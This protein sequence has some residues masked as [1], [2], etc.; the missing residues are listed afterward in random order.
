MQLFSDIPSRNGFD[1]QYISETVWHL[2]VIHDDSNLSKQKD[3]RRGKSTLPSQTPMVLVTDIYLLIFWQRSGAMHLHLLV[4][5]A[6][7]YSL[8]PWS[9]LELFMI[10]MGL[11]LPASTRP[12]QKCSDWSKFNYI[13]PMLLI[14][15]NSKQGCVTPKT[16]S[17]RGFSCSGFWGSGTTFTSPNSTD[18]ENIPAFGLDNDALHPR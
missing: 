16:Q 13:T 9:C 14:T 10:F 17:T 3:E 6:Y 8:N 4:N 7:A 12:L 2:G 5:I 1:T 11:D 18:F 15:C